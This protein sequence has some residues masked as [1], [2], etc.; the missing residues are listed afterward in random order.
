MI[1]KGRP[2]QNSTFDPVD[3]DGS[4]PSREDKRARADRSLRLR[5]RLE[6]ERAP[7]IRPGHRQ[8]DETLET[9]AARQASFDCRLDDGLPGGGSY[10]SS[11]SARESD[12]WTIWLTGDHSRHSCL[13][14]ALRRPSTVTGE[15]WR[16]ISARACGELLRLAM[17]ANRRAVT[18]SST[19][20]EW[21]RQARTASGVSFGEGRRRRHH[22]AG[23]GGRIGRRHLQSCQSNRD[24]RTRPS[25]MGQLLLRHTRRLRSSLIFRP[26]Q[27]ILVA[28]FTASCY[29]SP[30]R[31][32]Y[33]DSAADIGR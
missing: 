30:T 32:R 12:H 26:S 8:V 18:A 29:S 28:V 33:G 21:P 11:S 9:K 7:L 27:R 19:R 15:S 5:R 25:S 31:Q 4:N 1:P 14:A 23:A 13:P 10:I 22:H 24:C 16:G 6:S 20:R 2:D 17:F 3:L